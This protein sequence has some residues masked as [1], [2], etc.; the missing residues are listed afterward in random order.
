MRTFLTAD[1]ECFFNILPAI[2]RVDDDGL[3]LDWNIERHHGVSMYC[4]GGSKID[5]HA[6]IEDDDVYF[7]ND[8]MSVRSMYELPSYNSPKKRA[9]RLTEVKDV[10]GDYFGREE[11]KWHNT[12]EQGQVVSAQGCHPKP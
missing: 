4:S 3:G 12:R 5:V 9:Y 11:S 7:V 6:K 1:A 8:G 2:R 10:I